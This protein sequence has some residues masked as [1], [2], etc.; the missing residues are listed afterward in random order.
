M[1]V[2]RSKEYK[3]LHDRDTVSTQHSEETK[4]HHT[5]AFEAEDRA[6]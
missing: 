4:A 5:V 3:L 2:V 1:Q 6:L